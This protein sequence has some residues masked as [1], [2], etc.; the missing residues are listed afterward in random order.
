[1]A[2]GVLKR[3]FTIREIGRPSLQSSA[4]VVDALSSADFAEDFVV[5]RLHCFP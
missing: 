1:M 4:F 5:D 3:Q 2:F